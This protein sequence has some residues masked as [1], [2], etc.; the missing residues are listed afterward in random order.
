MQYFYSAQLCC[1]FYKGGLETEEEDTQYSGM[2]L[3]DIS[4]WQ[5]TPLKEY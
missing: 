3:L 2:I 5:V 4:D 1:Q